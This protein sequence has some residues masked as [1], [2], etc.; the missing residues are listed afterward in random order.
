MQGSA[1]GT[2]CSAE[3]DQFR[4]GEWNME[5]SEKVRNRTILVTGAT[6]LIGQAAVKG[7][8][9]WNRE[10]DTGIK[11][12][13][14]VRNR[15]K[16]ESLF[17][18]WQET[19]QLLVEDICDIKPENLKVDFIIHGASQTASRAFIEEPVETIR[20]AF[21]GT[22]RLLEFARANPVRGFVY[23]SS[24]EVY[25]APATDEKISEDYAGC[26]DPLKIRSC[27]PESKRMC[28]NLCA[29]YAAEYGVPV[30]IARLAQTFGEGVWYGDKRIFAEIARCV[31]E[32]RDIILNTG[33]ETKHC[34]LYTDDAVAALLTI[35]V[36]GVVGEAYNVANGSTYC[37][38]YEMAQ[39]AADRYGNQKMKVVINAQGDAGRFGYAPTL[40]MNLDTRKLEA[41]GWKPKV[42]LLEM[43]ER[44]I[45]D[46][47]SS[48]N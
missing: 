32:G 20:T 26:P 34:Y 15:E 1:D 48:K 23:L 30:K 39:M 3:R 44:M 43:Y 24:M 19:V 46:M 6:G 7:I 38:I 29:C 14:V 17:G 27:Y 37:S 21:L 12:I 35:L 18:D 2:M 47:C 9:R 8:C 25:G 11:V 41:L 45:K 40:K 10:S 33:G 31:I 4:E 16:A 36:K 5:L 13:A 28:E 22:E 42:G